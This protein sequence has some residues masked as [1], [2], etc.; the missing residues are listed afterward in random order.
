MSGTTS[1]MMSRAVNLKELRDRDE[2]VIVNVSFDILND[3]LI[4]PIPSVIFSRIC[5]PIG[6]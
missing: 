6:S 3:S 2:L 4:N 1:E 5:I